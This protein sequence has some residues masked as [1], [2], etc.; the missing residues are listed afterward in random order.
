MRNLMFGL[1]NGADR[2][3]TDQGPLAG[4][5]APPSDAPQ[6]VGSISATAVNPYADPGVPEL[7]VEDS[8]VDFHAAF[9][10][11]IEVKAGRRI[12]DPLAGLDKK[13][14][15]IYRDELQDVIDAQRYGRSL[16]S[17]SR[18]R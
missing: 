18:R 7:E 4:A 1:R 13:E 2:E 5:S 10:V 3:Q 6:P 17:L 15:A 11:V 14:R 12:P 8:T 16:G 9:E